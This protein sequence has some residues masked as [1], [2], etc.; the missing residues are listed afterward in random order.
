MT[1]P[2]HDV[3]GEGGDDRQFLGDDDLDLPFDLG[4]VGGR[5]LERLLDSAS[6]S[7]SEWPWLGLNSAAISNRTSTESANLR[8]ALRNRRNPRHIGTRP[9]PHNTDHAVGIAA[10]EA[11]Q[12]KA[13]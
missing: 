11:S 7:C 13:G 2:V 3:F 9:F 4:P 10:A 12:M 8:T 5:R 6:R 1:V